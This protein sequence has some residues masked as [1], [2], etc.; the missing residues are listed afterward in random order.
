MAQNQGWG[1]YGDPGWGGGWAPPPPPPQ[2]GVIPLRPLTVGEMLGGAMASIGRYK[3]AVFG[4]P[5]VVFGLYSV[6]V[7]VAVV[8]ALAGVS[9]AV[10]G[11]LDAVDEPGSSEP[12]WEELQPFVVAFFSVLAVLMIGYVLAVATVQAAMLAVL[13][14]AVVGR[15]AT[16]GS[17]WRQA[18]PRVPALIGTTLLSGLIAMVP[19]LLALVA[20]SVII[21][22]TSVAA[23]SGDGDDGTAASVFLVVG[24]LGALITV[25][26]A[27]WLYVKFILAP[28]AVVF[29][30]QGPIA[31]LRR[32]S[33]L[34]HGRW[35]PIAGI[36]VLVALIAGVI[37]G[38]VQQVLGMLGFI[39]LITAASDLGPEPRMA[40]VISMLSVYLVI[41]LLAQMAGYVI[42]STFPPLVNGLLY[43]DQRI[44]KENLAVA[45][46]ESAATPPPPAY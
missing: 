22:G 45:L 42:Q 36:S 8:V 21:I 27:V 17:V 29:E 30:K 44:R 3:S 39:P 26:P 15:P 40:D 25:V 10:P 5:L 43:V 14:N 23:A 24:V 16:F 37:A 11:F 41:V 32:S 33:Q 1:P 6:V 18:L 7:G 9:D 20:F 46:A 34:V 4:I 31:A 2:P 12:P 35:W 28:A 13:Q 19:T 38:V